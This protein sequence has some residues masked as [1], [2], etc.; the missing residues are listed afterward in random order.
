MRQ[1]ICFRDLVLHAIPKLLFLLD[2]RNTMVKLYLLGIK[3]SSNR[4]KQ[5]TQ[6]YLEQLSFKV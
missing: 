6:C 5:D 4:E 3:E 2:F 1:P